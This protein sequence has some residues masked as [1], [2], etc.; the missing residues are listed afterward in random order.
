MAKRVFTDEYKEKI[1]QQ[2][3]PPESRSIPE[4]AETENIPKTTIYSWVSKARKNGTIIPNSNSNFNDR[5]WNDQEKLKLVLETFSFNEE[6]LAQY[7]REKGLYTTDIKNWRKTMES[8]FSNGKPS[9]KLETELKSE[10]ERTKKLLR[11]LKYKEKALAETAA[12]LVLR[13]KA[14]AIWGDHEED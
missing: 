6:E 9:K 10:K 12:L 1:L 7:C 14:D 8:S 13:K 5:K 3:Q 2:L 4:I 11:E